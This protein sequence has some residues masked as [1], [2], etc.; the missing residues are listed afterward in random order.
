MT[1]LNNA[2]DTYNTIYLRSTDSSDLKSQIN[3]TLFFELH[4]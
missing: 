3:F 1:V 2:I 4:S